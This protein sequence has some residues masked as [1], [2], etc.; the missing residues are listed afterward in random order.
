LA[1]GVPTH[2]VS[3][4]EDEQQEVVASAPLRVDLTGGFTD[5]PPFSSFVDSLHINAAVDLTVSVRCR[6]TS[7][8][9]VR[10]GFSGEG[11][12]STR[13]IS[14]GR[15]RF[16]QA[17]QAG[18]APF[19]GDGGLDLS[20]HSG[21]PPGSGLGS[22]G[23]ILVAAI[24]GCARVAG[25]SLTPEAMAVK[26]IVAAAAAGI[27]GGRQDEF[28]AAHGAL[29]AYQFESG[30]G[31]KIDDGASTEVC[32]YLEDSLLVVQSGVGGRKTDIVAEVVRAVRVSERETLGVLVHLQDLALELR[33]ILSRAEFDELS[34][35]LRRIRETQCALHPR[36]CCPRTAALMEQLRDE[37]GGAME[38]KFLGGGGVG[39]CVLLYVPPAD[40]AAAVSILSKRVTKVWPVKIRPQGAVAEW[41]QVGRVAGADVRL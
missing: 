5:V 6:P 23:S 15:R 13:G 9:Q 7:G 40:R 34:S 11:H 37:V 28:A 38:Y 31:V 26:A 8:K 18:V 10:V 36:L 16:S 25:V 27:V 14:D 22:S 30:G 29:R 3:E 17:I 21:A 4:I 2:R 12:R 33:E 24:A 19:A 39:C 35:C 1:V 41:A 20:I 32:R